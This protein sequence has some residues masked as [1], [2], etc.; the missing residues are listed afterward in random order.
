MLYNRIN[1]EGYEESQDDVQTASGIVEDIR[2]VLL[3][4]QVCSNKP[5]VTEVRLKLG[6]S[7]DETSTGDIRPELQVDCE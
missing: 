2:D 3:D 4:H 5:Y 6:T 7:I 1:T